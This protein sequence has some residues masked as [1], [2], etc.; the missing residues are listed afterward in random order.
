M[1]LYA[2]GAGTC[3]PAALSKSLDADP[4]LIGSAAGL[5]GCTQ[6]AIGALC[7]FLA[8]MGNNPALAVAIVMSV[9][10]LCGQAGFWLGLAK[11]S[12]G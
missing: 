3:S 6:M 11:R 4:R 10:A 2:L 12:N 7:T 8:G 5:Y 9:A 1:F